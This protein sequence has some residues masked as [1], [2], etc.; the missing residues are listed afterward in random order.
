MTQ[1]L[2]AAGFG[3]FAYDARGHGD[4]TKTTSGTTVSYKYFGAP[5]PDSQWHAMIGDLD[6]AVRFLAATK[7]IKESSLVIAGAS[8]G[9]NIALTWAA[10]HPSVVAI[11]VL[12]PGL[13]YAGIETSG[14]ISQFSHRR[15]AFAASPNDSYAYQSSHMLLEQIASNPRAVFFEGKAGHGVQMFNGTFEEELVRWLNQ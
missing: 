12:S 15:I 6:R 4:S 9:A 8:V 3:Y 5:G 13:E 7:N 11:I 14:L 1:K 10:N 2:A